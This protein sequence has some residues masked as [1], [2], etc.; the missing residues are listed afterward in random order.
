MKERF[1]AILNE[2]VLGELNVWLNM[3]IDAEGADLHIKSNST[4][5]ARVNNDIIILSNEVVNHETIK[6]IVMDLTAKEYE[7]FYETG[8][9]PIT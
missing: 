8:M 3:L 9:S 2:N 5:H 4:I 6:A 7:K 1:M